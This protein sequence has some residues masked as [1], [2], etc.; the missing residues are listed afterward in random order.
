MVDYYSRWFDIK[1]LSDET[2]HSV[3]KAL[4]EVF[5]THGIPDVIMSDNGPQYSAEA[6]RQF[7]AAYHFTH[8]T[9]S[10][11]FHQANGEVERAIRTAKSMLRKNIFSALLTYRSTPLQNG[12]SPSEL[13]MGRRLQTQLPTHPANLY[14]NVQGK[15]RQLVEEKESS[16][17][18]NQQRNFDKRH[19]AKELPTLEPGDRVWIRDQVRCGLVI[20]KT[21]IP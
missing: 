20:E 7:A 19:K 8:V 11:K 9:S 10:P 18:L 14:P 13:L 3:I 21:E 6:F 12:Y 1:K 15:D 2:S 4:K 5:V 16:Y 17:R